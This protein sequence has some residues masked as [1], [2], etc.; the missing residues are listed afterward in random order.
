MNGDS[1]EYIERQLRQCKQ[2]LD[3]L[4]KLIN[5]EEKE[6]LALYQN[7][8]SAPLGYW[9]AEKA[10]TLIGGKWKHAILT[11]LLKQ[12]SMRYSQIKHALEEY[13]ITDYMLSSSLKELTKD[14]LVIKK[15]Y[16]EVPVRVEYSATYKAF[17]LWKIILELS[18]WYN[19]YQKEDLEKKL[20]EMN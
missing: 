17:E 9:G 15:T 3:L 13:G 4:E 5:S 18:Y 10:L 8:E 12:P 20:M 1:K 6:F 11:R 16:P 7:V 2:E 19:T 14:G